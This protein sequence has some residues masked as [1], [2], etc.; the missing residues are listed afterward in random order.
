MT[1]GGG[2]GGTPAYRENNTINKSP[3]GQTVQAVLPATGRVQVRFRRTTPLPVYQNEQFSDELAIRDC[4]GIGPITQDDF[5]DVTT[6]QT[7]IQATSQS[8]AT[9]ERKMQCVVTRKV[10]QRNEDNTFGPALV[11]SQNA[12]DIICH[13]ALDPKLGGR[14]LAE[15][16]VDQIYSTM[17]DVAT[18]FGF[19]EAAYF[20]YSFD[21]DNVSYEEMVQM[22]ANAVFCN[23]YRQGSVMRLFFERATEDASL[24]FGHRNKMP[25]SETRTVRFG[26]VDDQDGVEFDYRLENGEQK[27]IFI[28]PDQS[29]VKPRKI[30]RP[31]VT[32]ERQAQI[33]ADRIWNRMRYQNTTT[34]FDATAEAS[35]LVL[36]ERIEVADN[37]RPDVS[38]GHI[39]SQDGLILELSQPFDPSAMFGDRNRV[40]YSKQE[41]GVTGWGVLYNPLGHAAAPLTAVFL[42]KHYVYTTGNFLAAGE[43]VSIGTTG[44]TDPATRIPVIGGERLFVGFELG[45]A[46][47]IGGSWLAVI[48]WGNA[49]GLLGTYQPIASGFASVGSWTREGAFVE[50]ADVPLTATWGWVEVYAA[51]GTGTGPFQINLSEVIVRGVDDDMVDFPDF[52]PGLQGSSS[53]SYNIFIQLQSG[54][55]DVIPVTRGADKYHVVLQSPTS[56]VLV[57][58]DEN[59]AD[60]LYQIVG[61]SPARSSGF[62][63]SEKGTY[64]KRSVKVQAINY[65]SRYY[66]NDLDHVDE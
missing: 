32:D 62:L 63:V 40:A 61:D 10:L 41:A 6:V 4:Y 36:N 1:G 42:G 52:T 34:E 12:A 56:E 60:V 26:V 30:T 50:A 24:L 18:Y 53:L 22:V 13:M 64:D 7:R 11:P 66:Q 45:I 59:W 15:L 20:N 65:D 48:W 33:H 54:G 58:A 38:D 57:L 5:G 14:Q 29:A 17:S 47:P 9:K 27:T 25:G 43:S 8:T 2:G 37:T 28:P 55:L 39:V 23:A 3:R 46:I 31:G 49:A 51:S 44:S 21:D 35:Q 16:D 19:P